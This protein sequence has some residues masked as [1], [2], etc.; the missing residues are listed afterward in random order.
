MRADKLDAI[1]FDLGNTLVSYY[2]TSEFLPI[3]EKCVDSIATVLG[4]HGQS[5]DV[6]A[7]FEAAKSFNQE[8]DDLK[9]SPLADRLN[10]IFG[11][12]SKTLPDPLVA[13]MSEAFLEP[14]FETGKLDPQALPML[15]RVREMGFKTAIVS[16]TPWGSP[17]GPWQRELDRMGLLKSVDTVVFCVD[18]GWRKPAP[19]PFEEALSRLGVSAARTGFLGD[20][21]VW[22]VQGAQN[23]GMRPILLSV[24]GD[25]VEKVETISALDDLPTILRS[26]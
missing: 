9:V 15:K 3:L 10:Q 25:A 14:I 1:L 6:S 20:D 4:R 2:S 22:D 19:Q 26:L 12:S 21:I 11:D 8:R 7:A 13:E 16:N 23:I 18:V 17:A 24:N 5:T